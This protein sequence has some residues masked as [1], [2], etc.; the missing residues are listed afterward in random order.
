MSLLRHFF[1]SSKAYQHRLTMASTGHQLPPPGTPVMAE[2]DTIFR[3]RG[4]DVTWTDSWTQTLQPAYAIDSQ[5]ICFKIP[6]FGGTNMIDFRNAHL[7]LNVFLCDKNGNAP[8]NDTAVAP[9]NSFGHALF[10]G[11]KV[12]LNSQVVSTGGSGLYPYHCHIKNMLNNGPSKQKTT[13]NMAGFASDELGDFISGQVEDGSGFQRRRNM[14]GSYINPL[15]SESTF[16]FR[17]RDRPTE[18]ICSIDSDLSGLT[19]P[20]VS[21]VG[22]TIELTRNPASFYMMCLQDEAT[23]K[24]FKEKGYRLDVVSALL[25]VEVNTAN[26]S[27]GAEIEDDLAKKAMEY[28]IIRTDMRRIA[29][30][31]GETTFVTSNIKQSSTSPDR[32]F[33]VIVPDWRITG[34]SGENP[35]RFSN[36]LETN[37]A[38]KLD[39]RATLTNMRLSVNNTSLEMVDQSHTSQGLVGRKLFELIK[40]LGY[41]HAYETPCLPPELYS[42]GKFVFCYDFLHSKNASLLGPDIRGVARQ[43]AVTL[44]LNFDV[45]VPCHSWLLVFSEYHAGF[46]IDKSRSVTYQYLV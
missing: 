24:D 2:K 4:V 12:T 21:N 37:E 33:F 22:C 14:F 34:T 5:R 23:I 13:L 28:N 7:R 46:L 11:V 3:K 36:F 42:T 39:T 26:V 27:L 43:G 17:Q 10:S 19:Q 8:E 30:P 15:S 29:I 25:V 20:I 44:E 45:A 41:L 38:N 31:Q 9:I 32:I 6:D 18:I 35:L 1:R 40:Y 16:A